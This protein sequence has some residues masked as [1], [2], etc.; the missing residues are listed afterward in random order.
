M[1][2]VKCQLKKEYA[3]RWCLTFFILNFVFL[4]AQ[5]GCSLPNLEKPQCTAAR[6][7]VKRFYSYHF[8][9]DMKPSAENLKSKEQ[10]LTS[11][12]YRDLSVAKEPSI[13]YFT[14]TDDYPRAFR[15]GTCNADADDRARLQVVLL[16]RDDTRTEQKEVYVEAVKTGEKWLV[17]KVSK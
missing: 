2:H 6:D 11:D 17:N 1:Q 3:S 8:A 4:I 10:F 12:L 16:W 7:A 14:E 9:N 5:A 13:D 15:I